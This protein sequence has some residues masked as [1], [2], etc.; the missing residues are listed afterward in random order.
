MCVCV[1]PCLIPSNT[2][3]ILKS[4]I[5]PLRLHN[6][7]TVIKLDKAMISLALALAGRVFDVSVH[8]KRYKVAFQSRLI[9]PSYAR[10]SL[11]WFVR[12]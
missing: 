7:V 10:C 4:I 12:S 2:S 9:R 11:G 5:L 8:P 6:R 1:Q 3:D